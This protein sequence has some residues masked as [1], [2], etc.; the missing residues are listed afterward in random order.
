MNR[1]SVAS[2]MP[3]VETTRARKG[4]SWGETSNRDR[5]GLVGASYGG[6]LSRI[7]PAGMSRTARLLTPDQRRQLY[8]TTPD[9]RAC[10]DSIARRV[11]TWDWDVAVKLDPRDTGYEAAKAEADKAT[12]W[13]SAPNKDGETWQEVLVKMVTDLLTD[14]SGVW[15]L[16][17]DRGG[18]GVL[19]EINVL[20]G[21]YVYPVM[22]VHG[23][24][25]AYIQDP[26][27]VGTYDPVAVEKELAKRKNAGGKPIDVNA[28]GVFQG[29]I[30]S[31]TT[32]VAFTTEEI[33][34]FRLFPN[35]SWP[36]LG[37]PLMESLVNEVATLLLAADHLVS[38]YDADEIPPGLLVIGGLAG[39]ALKQARQDL[40]FMKGKDNKIR[41]IGAETAGIVDA[42]WIEMRRQLKDLQFADIIKEVRRTVFRVFGIMPIEMGVTEDMPRAVGAEMVDLGK[43]HLLEPILE[44]IA[45]KVN[46]RVL[47]RL[48][49]AKYQ[50]GVLKF[51]FDRKAKLSPVE[52][53]AEEEANEIAHRRGALTTNEWRTRR[54]LAPVGAEGDVLLIETGAGLLPLS[55]AVKAKL[56]EKVVPPAP[57]TPPGTPPKDGEGGGGKQ[58]EPDDAPEE[59]APGESRVA[60]PVAPPVPA[61]RGHVHVHGPECGHR[62]H[63]PTRDDLP[64][65][66]QPEGRFKGHR[67]LDLS[68][69]AYDVAE[70]E[71]RV[72]ALYD[73]ALRE[74]L[75]AVRVGFTPDKTSQ[76]DADRAEKRANEAVD[77]LL[78][79]WS[80]ETLPLYRSTVDSAVRQVR[81]WT[82]YDVDRSLREKRADGY[83]DRAMGYLA[84]PDGLAG[85]LRAIVD[86]S[87]RRVVSP[88]SGGSLRS[89]EDPDGSLVA[90]ISKALQ[91][92]DAPEAAAGGSA[93]SRIAALSAASTEAEVLGAVEYAF[94]AQRYRTA[95]WGGKLIELANE[96]LTDTLSEQALA[97][98]TD[99]NRDPA[100]GA[101][102]WYGEFVDVGDGNTCSVCEME[103]SLG[104]RP[105]SQIVIL[106]GSQATKCKA[107]CRCVVTVWTKAEVDAGTAVS[108][109]G[110]AKGP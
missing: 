66:W 52:L 25:A 15:E 56:P 43:S 81:R 88:S 8:E 26:V 87:L 68:A 32:T 1:Y 7:A 107:R 95:N 65:D 110:S 61:R 78:A 82:G 60:A 18:K 55:E 74:V 102:V 23:R 34:Q 36:S 45:A 21:A 77:K 11:S 108:L 37:M 46:A 101:V 53:K 39:T 35:T 106:P 44:L 17:S 40:E 41:L 97:A 19:T 14:D 58:P 28:E 83:H 30:A 38:A 70:Y 59:E 105:L 16:V 85:A 93:S 91:E 79:L 29:Q 100:L 12:A 54:G 89:L 64:S 96:T 73:D 22:G 42:K 4:G 24:I 76:E 63:T 51:E 62:A 48:L 94:D 20:R 10:V 33:V 27:G 75:S 80:A 3:V 6:M 72:V 69:L 103:G 84:A 99:P 86:E 90:A 50:G 67:T 57:G 71:G 13:L 2:T 31:G 98:N 5:K 9:V 47:Q 49:P 104:I 92:V 109:A